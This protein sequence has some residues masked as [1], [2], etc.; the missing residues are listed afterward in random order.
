MVSKAIMVLASKWVGSLGFN[1]SQAMAMMS[2][3]LLRT[4]FQLVH[5]HV[6]FRS[7]VLMSYD[8]C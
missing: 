6:D 5:T 3:I 1:T 7:R 8:L 4:T 2:V